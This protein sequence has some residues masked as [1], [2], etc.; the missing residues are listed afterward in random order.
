ME[1]QE[2]GKATEIVIKDKAKAEERVFNF[3]SYVVIG[4]DPTT[5]TEEKVEILGR[6]KIVNCESDLY[7]VYTSLLNLLE[8][9]EAEYPKCKIL[10]FYHEAEKLDAV[11][12]AI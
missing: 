9:I 5:E 6:R 12:G 10:K 3:S 1:Q 11:E 4:I 7:A 8:D 2:T